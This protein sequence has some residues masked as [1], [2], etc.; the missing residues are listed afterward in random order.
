MFG[1]GNDDGIISI[2][3]QTEAKRRAPLRITEAYWHAL[4]QDGQIPARSAI[5]PRGIES[6]LENAFLLEKISPTMA[7]IRVAGSLM[8]DLMG[9]DVTGMPLSTLIAA[10][11]RDAFGAAVGSLFAGPS[12][13]KMALKGQEGFGRPALAGSLIILPLRSDFGEVTRALGAIVTDSKIGRAPRRF[14]VADVSVKTLDLQPARPKASSP[15]P[16]SVRLDDIRRDA[17]PEPAHGGEHVDMVA[18]TPGRETQA[19]LPVRGHLRLVVSN[20]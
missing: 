10:D 14:H 7:K 20:D 6:A 3:P 13:V 12:I 5:D 18:S 8:S 11:D 19:A 17:A 16:R 15:A 2:T 9:M 4:C 1:K